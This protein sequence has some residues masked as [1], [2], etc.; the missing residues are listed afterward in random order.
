MPIDDILSHLY[1]GRHI[2]GVATISRLLMITGL[3][4]RVSSLLQ[5]SSAK[6][7][8]NFREPTHRSYPIVNMMKVE[9]NSC[10]L[11]ATYIVNFMKKDIRRHLYEE[12]HRSR[13]DILG[14]LGKTF[15]ARHSRQDILGKTF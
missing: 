13:Q 12:R 15:Q 8:C 5:G 10:L 6:E 11:K 1:E 9:I 2:Y 14:F 7:T 3:C 4:C